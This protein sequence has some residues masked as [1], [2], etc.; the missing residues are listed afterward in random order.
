LGRTRSSRPVRRLAAVLAFILLTGLLPSMASAQND[1]LQRAIQVQERIAARLLA[2]PGVVGLGV[3]VTERAQPRIR[4][5]TVAHDTAGVP[6]EA[7]GVGLDRVVTGL[8]TARACQ[9]TGNPAERCN[10]P[11]PIGVS[12]GH[13]DVT[14]GTIGARVKNG[15][16]AVFALSNN[17]VL[18]DSNAASVGDPAI[19]PGSFDGGSDPADRI[20]TLAAF[21]TISFNLS[22]CSN[23]ASDPDCNTIDAAIASTTTG[24]LGVSTL[25][26]GYGTPSATTVS[27]SI[28]QSVRKCGR[29]TNCTTG[30]VA[31]VN[32]IVDVC[33]VPLGPFCAPGGAARFVNQ[34]GISDGTFSAGGDSGSLIVTTSGRNPVGLLFAGGGN[35]TFANEIGR[36]LSNFDVSIDTGGGPTPTPTPTPG[37]TPTPTPT[38]TPN[39]TPTPTP[40]AGPTGLTAAASTKGTI[41]VDLR[42]SGGASTVAVQR[43]NPGSSSFATIATVSNS[44]SYRDNLGKRPGS[45]TYTYRVCNSGTSICSNSASIGVP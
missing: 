13:P 18:A 5:F 31:E 8:I 7:E 25:A 43:Q 1:G 40:V 24:N 30:T 33:Y 11:V 3:G 12:V 19:Q 9:D 6:N 21:K 41:K 32:V 37:P 36:V 29:T 28:G 27:P 20:G 26:A 42:W 34:I 39:P 2:T 44:G 35:R 4:V 16:G 38:S 14:A 17:H 23:V 45:G 10:R 15:S 22:G